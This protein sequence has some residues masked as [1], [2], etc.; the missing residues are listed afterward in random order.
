MDNKNT[1]HVKTYGDDKFLNNVSKVFSIGKYEQ[2]E[3][4]I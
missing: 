3:L 4:Y 2:H 1:N